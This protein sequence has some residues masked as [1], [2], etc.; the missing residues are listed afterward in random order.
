VATAGGYLYLTAAS[1]W[2]LLL[3]PIVL[4]LKLI[5]LAV[6]LG[7]GKLKALFAL[8]WAWICVLE[9]AVTRLFSAIRSRDR[10]PDDL[11]ALRMNVLHAP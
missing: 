8:V 11:N 10:Q 7:L 2:L 3:A 6:N 1:H 9:S 4:P 5:A